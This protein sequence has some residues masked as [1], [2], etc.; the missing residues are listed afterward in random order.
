MLGVAPGAGV[1]ST[2]LSSNIN[3]TIYSVREAVGDPNA[4]TVFI[5]DVNDSSIG[6]F[7][8]LPVVENTTPSDFT[9]VSRSDF[10]RSRPVRFA[11]PETGLTNGPAYYLGYFSLSTGGTLTFTRA[12]ATPPLPPQPLLQIQ[13]VGT[14]NTIS[15]ATTNGAT[16]KLYYT[17]A[18]GLTTPVLNWP[19]ISTNVTGNGNTNSFLDI[20]T[21][22]VR[23]YD[24]TAY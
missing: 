20:T 4:L 13:R 16:Y 9:S 11:D 3:N 15:F 1:I 8:N 12:V 19:S 24:V 21:D 14:S 22:P 6:D 18:T 7:R 23:F 17:N 5:G 2:S 10:Y